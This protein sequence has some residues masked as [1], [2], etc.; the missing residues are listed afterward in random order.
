M[1]KY[2]LYESAFEDIAHGGVKYCHYEDG[3][4]L[5]FSPHKPKN[6]G[7]RRLS[8]GEISKLTEHEKKWYA[9]CRA[10]ATAKYLLRNDVQ[11]ALLDR[12]SRL[13]DAYEQKLKELKDGE[14][15]EN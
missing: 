7:W 6:S 4:S 12:Y 10:E 2:K 14:N 8:D 9:E 15:A 11:D 13:L 1:V 3:R 5:I